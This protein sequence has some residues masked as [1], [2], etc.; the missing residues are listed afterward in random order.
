[1]TFIAETTVLLRLNDEKRYPYSYVKRH[2]YEQKNNFLQKYNLIQYM[3]NNYYEEN[4]LNMI[5]FF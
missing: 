5:I 1:M 4:L 3:D 2:L